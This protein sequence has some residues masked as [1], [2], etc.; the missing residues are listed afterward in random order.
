MR[1]ATCNSH[2]THMVEL[3]GEGEKTDMR[4]VVNRFF[5]NK[6]FELCMKEQT[7]DL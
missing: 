6:H 7:K 2:A 5:C 1:C 4:I 3:K